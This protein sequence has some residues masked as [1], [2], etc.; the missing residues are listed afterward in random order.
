M[1][2]LTVVLA[3]LVLAGVAMGQTQIT[4]SLHDLRTYVTPNATEIC[5]FCHT[6]HNALKNGPSG[7]LWN[8]ADSTQ[9]FTFFDGS[10][11]G[12]PNQASLSC[13]SCHDGVTGVDSYGGTSGSTNI[14]SSSSAYVGTD[15]QND[16]PIGIAY[17]P[18]GGSYNALAA[19]QTAGIKF[20]GGG[21]D[22][23]EC[24]SCHNPHKG[25]T[26]NY[27]LRIDNSASALCLACHNL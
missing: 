13:L 24:A 23:V 6:P 3:L 7:D 9:Q 25:A 17:P 8:H 14:P 5:I 27:F 21:T 18:T 19:A 1:R 11:T 4:N 15:L 16:H 2:Q 26:A 22:Q 20:F 10:T 12:T